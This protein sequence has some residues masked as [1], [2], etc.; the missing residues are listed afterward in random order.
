MRC[1]LMRQQTTLDFVSNFGGDGELIP[2]IVHH[3]LPQPLDQTE[4]PFS[5]QSEGGVLCGLHGEWI[6]STG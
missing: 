2:T 5:A 3:A 1:T 4:A 6:A